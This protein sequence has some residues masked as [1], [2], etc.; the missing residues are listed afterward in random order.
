MNVSACSVVTTSSGDAVLF[1]YNEDRNTSQLDQQ[2]TIVFYENT[3]QNYANMQIQ[4]KSN[5][6][7]S[8][9]AGMNS[10]GIAISGNGLGY[11]ELNPHPEKT[12]SRSTQ[13]IY[14]LILKRASTIEDA[15]NLV[16]DFDFGSSMAFQ[17]HIADKLGN[18]IIVCPG[19][20]KEVHIISKDNSYFISTNT[21]KLDSS[22]YDQRKKIAENILGTDAS[23]SKNDMKAVLK[24]IH[25]ESYEGYTYYSTI[26][27]LTNRM[28]YFYLASDF[29]EEVTLDFDAEMMKGEH[30][31]I[32]SD[33]FPNG[34]QKL[35][36]LADRMEFIENTVLVFRMVGILS[37]LAIFLVFLR[38]MW[39]LRNIEFDTKNKKLKRI[40]VNL[41]KTI[42]LMIFILLSAVILPWMLISNYLRMVIMSETMDPILIFYLFSWITILIY[43]G[44]K[45]IQK[46]KSLKIEK[47]IT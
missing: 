23:V 20:D 33:L 13:S 19:T 21:N 11:Y 10:E 9:R 30:S 1:G 37:I 5:T 15:K 42:F 24:E 31:Y 17:I 34:A 45:G 6:V 16:N 26:F 47:S 35:T 12:Y 38:S 27:D 36:D 46:Y 43:G 22:Q 4:A 2:T 44:M 28:L 29:S 3:S 14:E 25:Q 32:M 40:G 8:L 39:L 18:A 7:F 41:G